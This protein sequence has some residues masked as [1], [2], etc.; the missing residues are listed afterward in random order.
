MR[1]S[2]ALQLLSRIYE[3][4]GKEFESID[5]FIL[6]VDVLFVLGKIDVDLSTGIVI[7]AD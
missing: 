3:Q 2:E 7:Y 4:A 5:Q 1:Q 6:A